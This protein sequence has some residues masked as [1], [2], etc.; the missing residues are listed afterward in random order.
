MRTVRELRLA[1]LIAYL[2]AL[3]AGILAS[4]LVHLAFGR[5]GAFGWDGLNFFGL[6]E[7]LCFLLVFTISL[8]V[9]KRAVR[10]TTTTL[11]SAGLFVPTSAKALARP[12]PV[13]D[14]LGTDSLETQFAVIREGGVPIGVIGLEDSLVPWEE[15]PVVGGDIAANDLSVMFRKYP[16]VIVADGDTIHGAIR[17]EAYF[18]YLGA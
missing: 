3:I 18:K 8:W 4:G 7:G 1:G 14:G 11:L 10:V 12:I 16:V 2:A 9:F 13:L 17:R 15:A 5:R 6:L